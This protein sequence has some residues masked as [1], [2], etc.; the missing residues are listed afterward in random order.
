[1]MIV[2]GMDQASKAN[3]LVWAQDVKLPA[4]SVQSFTLWAGQNLQVG[5]IEVHPDPN[6]DGK[7]CVNYVLDPASVAAGWRITQTHL[8]IGNTPADIP[9]ANGN[10]IPGQFKAASDTFTP[11][12]TS[13]EYCGLTSGTVIAAHAVVTQT[14]PTTGLVTQ[15]Q[16]AWA[17]DNGFSGKNWARYATGDFPNLPL[18]DFSMNATNVYDGAQGTDGGARLTVSINGQKIGGADLTNVV[19]G[20][21][22]T[23][24]KVVS[25]A[26]T[27][28]IEIRN[29]AA[30]YSGNDFAI[31]NISLTQH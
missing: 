12:V 17:G 7:L 28:H 8:A 20:N 18:Y 10:P 31:D 25:Y 2:N 15:T 23:I 24:E 14:N 16:T 11:G 30:F 6:A 13:H 1:M 5:K 26:G 29:E 4:A 27:A 3:S 22:I 21:Q 19:P 9:Q